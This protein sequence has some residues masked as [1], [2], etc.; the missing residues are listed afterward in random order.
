MCVVVRVVEGAGKEAQLGASR[1]AE[2]AN[3][4]LERTGAQGGRKIWC[5]NSTSQRAD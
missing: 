3:E 2:N 1:R 5:P 4:R